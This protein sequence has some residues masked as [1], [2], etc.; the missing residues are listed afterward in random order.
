MEFA[1]KPRVGWGMG[2][3]DITSLAMSREFLGFVIGAGNVLYNFLKSCINLK[4]FITS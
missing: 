2:A 3:I 4:N 1:S